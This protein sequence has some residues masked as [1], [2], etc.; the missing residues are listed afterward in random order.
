MKYAGI[1]II[2]ISV[3]FCAA[4]ISA[5]VRG[6]RVEGTVVSSED[7]KP[8]AAVAVLVDGS[9]NWA[10]SDREGRFV[11]EHVAAGNHTVVFSL[12]GYVDAEVAVTVAGDVEGVVA[13]MQPDNLKIDEVVVT[14]RAKSSEMSTTHLIG[15]HALEHLQMNSISDIGSL[16]PGASTVNPDL[17]TENVLSIRD[18]GVS[19]GNASFGTALE[20]DGVRI[21]SNASFS[22]MSGAG[23]RNVATA[24]VES[25]EV[26]TGVPSAEYGDIGTGIVKVNTSKGHTPWNIVL[27]ANP[28][29]KS[30]SIA[31][32][33]DLGAGK[34]SINASA[35]YAYATKDLMSP[36]ESYTRRSATLAYNNVFRKAW[37]FS[38]GLSGNIGGMD[39][40]SDPDANTGRR[41]RERDNSVRLR[42]SLEWLLNRRWITNLLF[43]ASG[44]YTDNRSSLYEPVANGS[45][46]PA[47]HSVEAGYAFA[48]ILPASFSRT[49]YVDS[50]E[51]D[52][53]VRLRG[54]WDRAWGGLRSNLKAGLS[55]TSNGNVGRGEYYDVAEY[56]PHGYRPRPYSD[57]PFMHTAA[58][59]V[60]ERLTVPLGRENFSVQIMAGLRG[61]K[62]IVKGAQYDHT[63]TLSPRLN[64]RIA[65]GR[66]VTL[67]GGWGLAG[68]LPS[69]YILYP[70]QEYRDIPVFSASYAGGRSIYAYYTEPYKQQHN[71]SLRWQRNRNAEAGADFS[72]GGFDIAVTGYF[73]RT[74]LPYKLASSYVPF[75][76]VVS[77]RPEGYQIPSNPE[78]RIDRESGRVAVRDAS[79]AVERWTYMRTVLENTTF[80]STT[81]QENGSDV[82]RMGA[83]ITIDFPQIEPLRTQFRL[84]GA[85][86]Y[87]QYINTDLVW[88][89]PSGLSHTDPDKSGMSYQFAGLY[90]NTPSS[91]ST[92][93]GR[94]TDTFSL[95]LTGI[96]RIPAIRMVVTVRLEAMLV[97]RMLNISRY[98]GAEYA[99]NV[100]ADS[101]TPTGGSVTSG[102]S[103][104]AVRPLQY[105][106]TDGTIHDFTDAEAA[107]P[108]FSNLIL[109]SGNAYQYAPDGYDPYFSANLSITKEFGDHVSLSFYANNFTMSR[110]SVRSYATGVAAIFTPD[111]YY[112]LS[113]RLKF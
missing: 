14:A 53:N 60:E 89:Y 41:E 17:T 29:T 100:A 45:E 85:Y 28:R 1:L 11:L 49:Q 66:H 112:G 69:F 104:T 59:F 6:F 96:T 37:R 48:D 74:K 8:L 67:R 20:V 64:V 109:R 99:Y 101:N 56:A 36:Y 25:V 63:S 23:S 35:E 87:T 84:D 18:G 78:F 68:K 82:D 97:R 38:A 43:E 72:F 33:F 4:D 88:Y 54:S 30:A 80:V 98:K 62:T 31:K 47:M 10:V 113:L 21:S 26:I 46:Q 103:Y 71:A 83:E 106:D 55:W 27:S 15:R 51:L 50:R 77:E 110:A 57:Y 2:L 105:M 44:S 95:N 108:R 107:D 91:S 65:L 3:L 102:D 42:T 79:E 93:N 90:V 34:G 40:R 86:H 58:L 61:E 94:R 9:D 52:L 5:A 19:A 39:T 16:L 75:T 22:G 92:F 13:A 7:R 70:R 12:L 24:N 111:F 81:R 73:N 76:Y 32:G